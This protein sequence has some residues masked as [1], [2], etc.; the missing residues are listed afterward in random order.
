MK[1]LLLLLLPLLAFGQA[2]SRAEYSPANTLSQTETQQGWRL[3]WDGKSTAGWTSAKA[4][5]FPAKG[6]EIR[7]GVWSVIPSGGKEG[8]GVT[9]GGDIITIEKF[10]NFE[11][12][13]DFKIS[14][15]TNSGIK[16]FVAPELNKGEGS[17]IGLEYQIL[18]DERHPDAKLGRN[19]NRT[20]GSLY[21]LIPPAKDK[22]VNPIGQWNTARILVRGDHVEHWLNGRKIVEYTRFTP[23]F[24][25]LVSESKYHIW[26]HFGELKEGPILLQDHGDAVSFRNIKIRVLNP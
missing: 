15:G 21:D 24:R 1:K 2:S 12:S 4:S 26:P 13:V 16:Y 17:A 11:L 23:E 19:G 3:L 10:S 14:P 7:D 5:T 6:W 8:G 25:Q 9:A 22:R 18:D 20:M